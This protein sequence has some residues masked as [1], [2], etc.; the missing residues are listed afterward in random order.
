MKIKRVELKNFKRF[1]HLIVEGIP[2]TT[3]LILLVGPNGSG[4]TS[5]MEAFNHYHKYA[6]Y[7]LNG[8]YKYFSK[9]VCSDEKNWYEESQNV[10]DI[11]FYDKVL[12][13]GVGNDNEIKSCFYFRSA[14]RN[15]P[16]FKIEAMRKQG[17][18]TLS[19]RLLSLVEN[20]I[21]VS[22]NYQRLVADSVAMLYSEQNDKKTVIDLRHELVGEIKMAIERVFQD[23]KFSSLGKPLINGNFYFDK[24]ITKEFMYSNLSAGEKSAFDLILDMVVQSKYFQNAIYCIDEPEIHMH[25]NL[26]GKVL[27]ELYNLIPDKSQLIISTHSIGMISEAEEIE[28]EYPGTVIFLDF[29]GRNFDEGQIL[30]P[31]KISKVAMKK[32]YELAFGDF[33]K[34]LLPKTIVFCEGNGNGTTR[35]DYDKEIY[36]TIFENTHPEAL[37]ISG[38]SCGEIENIEKTSGEIINTLLKNVKV[39]KLIDRDNRSVQE[40][41]EL[42]KKGIT[43][44][45]KRNM[46]SYL[47]DDEVIKELCE[48]VGK[49]DEYTNCL[50]DKENALENSKERGNP[51]DDYKSARGDIYNSLKKR[52]ELNKCGNNADT[53]IRDT[54]SRFIKPG[55]DVYSCL[56]KE[57]FGIEVKESYINEENE[58]GIY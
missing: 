52:L 25:T 44:L 30:Y 36:S 23:L 47:L 37:F 4:K 19:P 56:E 10:V 46:E 16:N 12:K 35:K 29:D 39:I 33:A 38:G 48:F 41:E 1:T 5:F 17:D 9:S 58:N 32:F 7:M 3:K 21:T 15:E 50:S 43:V 51:V 20:D 18:P 6:G 27:R 11:D 13:K 45:E 42:N 53:F 22:E 34:L 8:D 54:L 40:I 2:K 14:Y 49:S 26:Q 57:I 31:T 28:N 24:G 55:M